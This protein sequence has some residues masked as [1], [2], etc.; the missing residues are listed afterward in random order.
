[1]EINLLRV[2]M[3]K[4]KDDILKEVNEGELSGHSIRDKCVHRAENSFY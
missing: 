1:M 2:V 4:E 3:N